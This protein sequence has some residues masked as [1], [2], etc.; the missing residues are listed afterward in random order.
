MIDTSNIP[1]HPVCTLFPKM[2]GEEYQALKEDIRVNG[3]NDN[4]VMWKGQL[5]DGRH[6]IQAANELDLQPG[7]QWDIKELDE[8]I[9]PVDYAISANLH[10]RSLTTSQRAMVADG[11]RKIHEDE[12]KERKRAN[13]G[14]KVSSKAEKVNLPALVKKAQSRDKA[15]EMF[16]VSGKSV[17]M[18][19]TVKTKGI[20]ELTDAVNAGDV[21]VS[22]AAVVAEGL[23]PEEQKIAVDTKTV[24]KAASAIRKKKRVDANWYL[25]AIDDLRRQIENWYEGDS[26]YNTPSRQQSKKVLDASDELYELVHSCNTTLEEEY[27]ERRISGQ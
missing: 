14:D 23:S 26:E 17:D 8:G 6:R 27:S 13:G 9:N 7:D 21:P 1:H 11:L 12:A 4:P 10:R 22:S 19:R 5:I 15:A 3:M 20:P 24:P 18:A 25:K 16:G 2:T